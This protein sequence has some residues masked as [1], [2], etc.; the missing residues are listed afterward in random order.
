MSTRHQHI[1]KALL[2]AVAIAASGSVL[3]TCWDEASK[4]YQ[5]PIGVLKGIAKTESNFNAS[6][7]NLNIIA[8]NGNSY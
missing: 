3:G 7:K 1:T 8:L 2:A 6:A 5:I 4:E